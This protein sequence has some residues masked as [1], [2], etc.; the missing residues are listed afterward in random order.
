MRFFWGGHFEFLCRP[1]WIFFFASFH[2]KMQPI[3]MRDHFFLHYGWFFQNLRKEAVRTFMHTTVVQNLF[4]YSSIKRQ[5]ESAHYEGKMN[6]R[7]TTFSF[8]Y[9]ELSKFTLI[10]QRRPHERR[11]A[12]NDRYTCEHKTKRA[13]FENFKH[14]IAESQNPKSKITR[15]YSNILYNAFCKVKYHYNLIEAVNSLFFTISSSSTMLCL[16]IEAVGIFWNILN[17][18][19][20]TPM[21]KTAKFLIM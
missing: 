21:P 4:G 2:W 13:N 12:P 17:I 1:F 19:I 8:Q 6:I 15:K 10:L 7:F 11:N 5:L 20:G 9:L 3:S 18:K 14:W 16:Q